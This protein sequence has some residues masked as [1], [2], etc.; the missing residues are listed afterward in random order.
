MTIRPLHTVAFEA[1]V[2]SEWLNVKNFEPNGFNIY[3]IKP[4]QAT[5][6]LVYGVVCVSVIPL[7]GAFY[8]T[9]RAIEFGLIRNDT[10]Q[11]RK[12][13]QDHTF[14]AF[15]DTALVLAIPV[16]VLISLMLVKVA[17]YIAPSLPID[18]DNL[19][20]AWRQKQFSDGLRNWGI[21]IGV[22]PLVHPIYFSLYPDD[23]SDFTFFKA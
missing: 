6:R 1:G 20:W 8:H 18:P 16:A 21:V 12:R 7:I 10:E 23:Y 19:E 15:S 22:L 17:L 5:A 11:N 9:I 3:I 13:Y 4:F 14:A 2:N